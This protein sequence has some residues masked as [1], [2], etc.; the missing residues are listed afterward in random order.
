PVDLTPV[1]DPQVIP[2]DYAPPETVCRDQ[3]PR[4]EVRQNGGPSEYRPFLAGMSICAKFTGDFSGIHRDPDETEA[5][6]QQRDLIPGIRE[7]YEG[8]AKAC[9]LAAA[10]G[11]VAH[12]IDLAREAHALWPE[13]AK[14]DPVVWR[15]YSDSKK[16]KP[17]M[18]VRPNRPAVLTAT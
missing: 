6:G 9:H 13:R 1:A 17:P 10:E 3:R 12:A 5:P 15:L 11:R 7:Q 16:T 14:A 18:T 2:S 8:I 4:L